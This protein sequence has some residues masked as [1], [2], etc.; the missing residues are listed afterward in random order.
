LILHR[1]MFKLTIMSDITPK[2]HLPRDYNWAREHPFQ[3]IML[4]A[5]SAALFAADWV[6]WFLSVLNWFGI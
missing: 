6:P 4:F 2:T 5:F 1:Q 3:M